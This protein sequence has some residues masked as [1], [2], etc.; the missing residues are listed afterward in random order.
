MIAKLFSQSGNKIYF[1]LSKKDA[2]GLK[3]HSVLC[4]S[5]LGVP[6]GVLYQ[7]VWAR[8]S[9]RPVNNIFGFLNLT[10]LEISSALTEILWIIAK[11]EIGKFVRSIL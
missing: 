11:R 3:V 9:L 6:L 8:E 2:Q 1:F 10:K 7:K 4:V 5:M